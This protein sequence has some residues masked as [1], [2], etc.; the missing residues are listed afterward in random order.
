MRESLF[1]K[2]LDRWLGIPLVALLGWLGRRAEL[3]R[4]P[5]RRLGPGARVLAVKLSALGDT[6]LLLPSLKALREQLGDGGRLE[7]LCTRVNAAALAGVPW[8]DELHVFEPGDLW[9]RPWAVLALLRALRRKRFDLGLDYEQ[10]LRVTPLLLLA[11]GPRRRAGFDS[12]GQH[13]AGLFHASAPQRKGEHESDAFAALTAA[14]GGKVAVEDYAGFLARHG[15]YGARAW[16]PQGRG[17]LLHPGCGGR[18]WQREW[19][20][21][22]WIRLAQ[23]LAAAGWEVGL[24]GAGE[25][26]EAANARIAAASPARPVP[27]AEGLEALVRSLL[28]RRLLISGNTGVMHLAA[29]LGVPLLALHGPTDPVKWGPRALPGRARVL[30]AGIACSPCLFYGFDYGCPRRDCMEAIP[31]D[32]VKTQAL[33]LLAEA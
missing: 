12:P 4:V 27:P 33:E 29:G 26:E 9:R 1:F 22:R 15:L 18:G 23:D 6:L 28:S 2:R 21:E 11:A 5:P 8:V 14:A 31:Q 13:R 30:E 24:S 25:R 17:V 3:F 10:W 20:E 16:T 32:R 19:P 7:L